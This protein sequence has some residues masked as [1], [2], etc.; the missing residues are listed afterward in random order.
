MTWRA[1]TLAAVGLVTALTPETMPGQA[2]TP[3]AVVEGLDL[4]RLRVGRVVAH[5]AEPDRERAEEMAAL[6]DR[7]AALY[8]EE[9]GLSFDLELA[10]LRPEDWFSDIPGIPYAI[11]WPSMKERLL[12]LPSSLEEGLLIEGRDALEDRRRVDFV[13]LH[14]LG[15]VAAREYFR[16]A[17]GEDYVPVKWFEELVAT[18]F[19][20]AYIASADAEWAGAARREWRRQV[21]GFAPPVRSLDW[22]FM[23][24]LPGGELARVYGWYQFLLNLRA[25]ELHERHG[26]GLLTV[27]KERLAWEEAQGWDDEAVLAVFDTVAPEF[28][29]WARSFGGDQPARCARDF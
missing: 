25:A 27:L 8:E 20:Y 21:E 10:A 22:S 18:Y 28:S 3:R 19:A 2:P 11:P 17:S 1:W 12:L 26:V 7:A 6:V 4:E 29:R 16:P 9:L 24:S 23:N 13:A 14:E 5:F 15:H